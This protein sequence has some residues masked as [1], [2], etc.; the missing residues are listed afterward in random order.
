MGRRVKERSHKRRKVSLTRKRRKTGKSRYSKRSHKRKM[1]GGALGGGGGGGGGGAH[2]ETG[3]SGESVKHTLHQPALQ[4]QPDVVER[5]LLRDAQTT[6]AEIQTVIENLHAI[7]RRPPAPESL[8]QHAERFKELKD[9]N[10]GRGNEKTL[11][12]LLE[13]TNIFRAH[14]PRE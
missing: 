10:F 4:Q 13:H 2:A 12:Y 5:K 11:Q 9:F 8:S 6:L 14:E 3:D 7:I 1:M